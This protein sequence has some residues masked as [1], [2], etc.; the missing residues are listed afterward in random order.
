MTTTTSAAGRTA[1]LL[2][3]TGELADDFGART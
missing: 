1:R 2:A 3:L